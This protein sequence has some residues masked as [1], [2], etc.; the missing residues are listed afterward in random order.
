[1][2][3][4]GCS[5]V[6][7]TE[8]DGL[9]STMF[10]PNAT[11]RHGNQLFFGTANGFVAFQPKASYKDNDK[12]QINLI[13]TDILI[14]G[15]SVLSLDSATAANITFE[16]PLQTHSITIPATVRKFGIEFSLLSY[17][18][19]S[20]TQYAYQL[21]GY[22]DDWQYV[23]GDFHRAIFD[24]VPSGTYQFHLR[25]ADSRGGWYELPYTIT[26][27]VL[28]PWYA[29]W[30]AYLIYICLLA[31]IARFIWKYLQMRR[32]M[33]ASRRFSTILQSA[34][35]Q[36]ESA[37]MEEEE[38]EELER[39]SLVPAID[40]AGQHKAEFI[41]HA[42]QL[43]RDH[44]DDSEYNRDRMAA[45]LG[46]SV[47]SL[48]SRLR[49]CTDLSIQTFIQTIRLNA[50]ADILRQH[51][52]IRISELAYRVGFNTPKYFSQ[53]FKKE[54]GVLPGDYIKNGI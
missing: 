31:T 19:Q 9:A 6:S 28:A 24:R 12:Y 45:D 3:V 33:K 21:E 23:G 11:F 39:K 53:C 29:T 37:N 25:A 20:E 48:Y 36:I 15:S 43:V 32:E 51:P 49:E 54:F 22:D 46:M 41:A 5:T 42:T 2:D 26:V 50:A 40:I 4:T 52:D 8:Q 7:F 44:L 17:A 38:V 16:L 1:L 27:H 47:S 30:W 35:I 34:Q 18:N 10:F 13:V 14:D